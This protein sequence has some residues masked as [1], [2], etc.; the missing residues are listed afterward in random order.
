MVFSSYVFVLLFLPIVIICYYGLSYVNKHLWQR[1][2]L[3]V[4]SLVFYGYFN[5]NYLGIIIVSVVVNYCIALKLQKNTTKGILILGVLFNVVLLGYYKYFNFFVDNI[6]L[7]LGTHIFVEK[8]LLPLGISFFTFQQLSFLISVY[9]GEERVGEF[10][11]YSLFVL[12]F[13]QLVAGPIVL[14]KEMI[15]QFQDESRYYFSSENFSRGLYIFTIGLFKKAVIADT[16]AIFVNHGYELTEYSLASSWCTSLFYTLQIYYDFSGYTDMAIGLGHM[17]NISIPINFNSPYK[18]V[19]IT[20]FWRRW[21]ITLGRAL[22]M[23]IYKPLGGNRNGISR[24]CFNLMATFLVS[25]LWHGASW[26]FVLWGALH[27][28]FIVVERLLKNALSRIPSFVRITYTFLI[29][30][31]LWVLFRA[32]NVD[33]AMAVYRGMINF[34]RV[35]IQDIAKMAQDG[36]VGFPN[37]IWITYCSIILFMTLANVL[38]TRNSIDLL[39]EFKESYVNAFITALLF[40]VS[41]VCMS[42]ESIFIYFN[43]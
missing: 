38:F 3:I 41:L 28:L 15:C 20:D 22:S 16:V 6:N 14:Y 30:N 4:A 40:I 39:N 42:R 5:L 17:F 32:E 29:V 26:T 11:D 7:V 37:S 36:I 23:Y 1:V 21:H 43:F 25:G 9:K 8:I 35:G 10:K 2:F 13:P 18:A 24:T 19:S 27:G 12:F 31:A 34:S 33:K